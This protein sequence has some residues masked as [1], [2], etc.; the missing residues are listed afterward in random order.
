MLPK[1]TRKLRMLTW[2]DIHRGQAKRLK[3]INSGQRSIFAS[4]RFFHLR[5]NSLFILNLPFLWGLGLGC[6]DNIFFFIIY[7]FN[8]CF[9]IYDKINKIRV[10]YLF[11][12]L[13]VQDQR[14]EW[15]GTIP[16]WPEAECVLQWRGTLSDGDHHCQQLLGDQT[17]LCLV[18]RIQDS[19]WV[20]Q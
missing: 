4:I 1:P 6:G 5:R 14:P 12:F 8:N 9:L 16:G 3:V 10:Q 13:Q 17:S 15:T 19:W 20:W 18:Q 11:V 2:K 7:I